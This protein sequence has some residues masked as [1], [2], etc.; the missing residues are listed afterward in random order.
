MQSK[1][2]S[3]LAIA[4]PFALLLTSCAT[5][6][7]NDESGQLMNSGI[8]QTRSGVSRAQTGVS[9]YT[10]GSHQ[11]AMSDMTSGI[12]MMNQGVTDMHNA[13]GMMS[14]N[15]MMN[16]TDGGAGAMFGPMQKA[17]DEINQ[18]QAKLSDN[19]AANDTDGI[20]QMGGGLS[21]MT[22]ALDQAQITMNC[23]GHGHMM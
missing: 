13:F 18:G 17:M 4:L 7:A 19:D 20:N 8:A 12:G 5:Y 22:S 15:M 23:M 11:T 21:M 6:M 2:T 14:G 16:C 9:E 10:T 1:L 3:G